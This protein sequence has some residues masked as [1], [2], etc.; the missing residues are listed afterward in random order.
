MGPA[1]AKA[2]TGLG[3][4]ASNVLGGECGNG[5]VLGPFILDKLRQLVTNRASKLLFLVGE[6]RRDVIQ[7]TLKE[8]GVGFTELIVYETTVVESFRAD[9]LKV[10]EDTETTVTAENE[11]S[12][13]ERWV[14]VFSPQGAD[15][16]VK[17]LRDKDVWGRTLVAAIG[18]TTEQRLAELGRKPDSVARQPSPE[19]L[20]EVVKEQVEK[21]KTG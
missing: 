20:W 17:A 6:T 5:A 7:K 2:V 21:M 19:G 10:L 14:A 16:A 9:L 1:T 12:R 3:F 4:R 8:A 13:G 18:P 15:V 11:S